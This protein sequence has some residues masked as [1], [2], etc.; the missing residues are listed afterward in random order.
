MERIDLFDGPEE[1]VFSRLASD[2]A[3]AFEAPIALITVMDGQRRFWEAQCGLPAASLTSPE[4]ARDLSICSQASFSESS[5]VV[6]DVAEDERFSQDCFLKDN[7]IR[8]YAGAPLKAHDDT[9]IGSICV[10][11][12]RPRQLSEHQKKTLVFIANAVMTAIELHADSIPDESEV[13]EA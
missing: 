13:D 1:G 9:I 7:G 10:L 2:L 6:P 8:F 11:D 4:S 12:T 5:L 3:R